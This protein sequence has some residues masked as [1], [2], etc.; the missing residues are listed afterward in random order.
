MLLKKR[1]YILIDIIASVSL[2]MLIILPVT[3]CFL[4]S[5]LSNSQNRQVTV[6][7]VLAQDKIEELK[8]LP[9]E[10][11]TTEEDLIIENVNSNNMEFNRIT[12][13]SKENPNLIFLSVKV[14]GEDY[15]VELVT[16]RTRL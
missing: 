1:G 13:I 11:L 5:F 16:Y 9:F 15:E 2:L 3:K 7:T 14:S 10:S 12:K 4:Q 8:A 6:A